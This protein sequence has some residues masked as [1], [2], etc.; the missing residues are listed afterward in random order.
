MRRRELLLLF[1]GAMTAGR[2]LRAQ[3]R[4]MPGI[5]YLH[6]ASPSPTL[7]QAADFHRGLGETGYVE[8]ENVA[9][10]YRWAE[11]HYDQLPALAADLVSRKVNVVV[12]VSGPSAHATR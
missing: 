7:L 5:G 6:F 1:G 10:E 2:T 9:I 11:R 4:A 12:A 8:G 3:Q